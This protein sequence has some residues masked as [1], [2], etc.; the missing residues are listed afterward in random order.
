MRVS[1]NSSLT[2]CGVSCGSSDAQNTRNFIKIWREHGDGAVLCGIQGLSTGLAPPAEV[3]ARPRVRVLRS[4]SQG[5]G[6]K[7]TDHLRRRQNPH[8]DPGLNG[9]VAGF[10]RNDT[11]GLLKSDASGNTLQNN[12]RAGA[13]PVCAAL[14]PPQTRF[15]PT[16]TLGVAPALEELPSVMRSSSDKNLESADRNAVKSGAR[17][18]DII[19]HSPKN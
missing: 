13:T 4:T 6:L 16:V 2:D 1:T 10:A 9:L 14:E 12:S 17:N 19:I 3:S 5:A 8:K 18:N 11:T 7:R 15:V